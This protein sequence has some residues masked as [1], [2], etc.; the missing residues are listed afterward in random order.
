ME[1][2][3]TQGI[4]NKGNVGVIEV[5]EGIVEIKFVAR[6]VLF[7]VVERNRGYLRR[8]CRPFKDGFSRIGTT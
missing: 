5:G 3:R 2:R 7:R 1:L 6:A 4:I 8:M